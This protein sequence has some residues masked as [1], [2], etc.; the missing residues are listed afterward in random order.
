VAATLATG[1]PGLTKEGILKAL[2][3]AMSAFEFVSVL[4]ATLFGG[5]AIYITLVEHP[6]RMVCGTQLAATVFGPSYRRPR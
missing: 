1:K 5:A 4:A 3:V 2:E 6:A